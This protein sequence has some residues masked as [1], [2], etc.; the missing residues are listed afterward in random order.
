MPPLSLQSLYDEYAA[1]TREDTEKER[2]ADEMRSRLA[3]AQGD[4]FKTFM[5]NR[6]R[7]VTD[8][9]RAQSKDGF[10]RMADCR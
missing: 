1:D 4:C 5:L 8:A 6:Q 10:T 7:T 3:S 9:V 2:Q